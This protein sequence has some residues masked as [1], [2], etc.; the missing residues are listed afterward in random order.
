MRA[1]ISGLHQV[2]HLFLETAHPQVRQGEQRRLLSDVFLQATKAHFRIAKLAFDH[3]KRMLNLGS[4]L[5]FVPL[6]VS[7]LRVS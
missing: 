6:G 7:L 5:R 4:N 1:V 3:S 2:L